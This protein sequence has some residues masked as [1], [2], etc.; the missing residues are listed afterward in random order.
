MMAWKCKRK[1]SPLMAMCHEALAGTEIYK[2]SE[3]LEM[4]KT[5]K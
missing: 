3:E 1:K 4:Q 2:E 5:L